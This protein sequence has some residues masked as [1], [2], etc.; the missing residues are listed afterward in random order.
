[1]THELDGKIESNHGKRGTLPGMIRGRYFYAVLLGAVLSTVSIAQ[2]SA[3]NGAHTAEPL[4]AG[5]Q[6]P[7]QVFRVKPLR[8]IAELRAEAL[9]AKPPEEQGRFYT[10]ALVDLTKVD[11]SLHL[12]IRYATDDNFL[13]EPVYEQA[14]AFLQS[15]AAFAL[16]RAS[17]KLHAKGYG[18][19]VYDAYRPWYVT[20]IF[21]EATPLA[22][23][24]F[25]ADPAQGSRHNRGCAVDLT[26]YDLKNGKAVAMP[27]GYDE[28]TPRAYADYAGASAEE[29]E[30]RAILREAM[31]S[32]GFAQMPN[33][34]WHYDYKEWR[35]YQILN[36]RFDAVPVA[37]LQIGGGVTPP[38]ILPFFFAKRRRSLS[39]DAA[40]QVAGFDF[41]Q[42]WH[43]GLTRR[44]AERAAWSE[45]ASQRQRARRRDCAFDGVQ[46]L[47]A[48]G[49][50][51]GNRAE[52][53]SGVG[54]RRSFKERAHGSGFDDSSGIHHRHPVADAAHHSKVVRDKEHG[55]SKALSQLCQQFENLRLYRNIERRR[56]LVGDEQRRAVDDCH[57]D[58]DP[59]ALA[60][61]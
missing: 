47:V 18:L 40:H 19:L 50:Q 51:R 45:R 17:E 9:Q 41:D 60:S 15:P 7:R 43:G 27:S 61:G 58:H 10:P 24:E 25:V 8:P 12:E 59:L 21:W 46:R 44:D 32:E 22:Q 57:G 14:R 37:R 11:S 34:W 42:L 33:E 29:K 13:G 28:M 23:R 49:L 38:K 4:T 35:K 2:D 54:V 55:K 48:I 30:H 6:N 39:P 3:Q 20:K 31:E 5:S 1:L 52:Q 53:A 36:L 16:K 26:L 56:G